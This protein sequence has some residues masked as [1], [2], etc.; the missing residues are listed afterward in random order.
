M[1]MLNF[2]F[3]LRSCFHILSFINT[4]VWMPLCGI[5]SFL[6][7][8]CRSEIARSHGDSIY[9][10]EGNAKIQSFYV[11]HPYYL[12]K[13]DKYTFTIYLNILLKY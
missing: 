10:L 11:F 9:N 7:V 3:H 1:N 13:R 2:V 6:S 8:L 4:A 5:L 12:Y